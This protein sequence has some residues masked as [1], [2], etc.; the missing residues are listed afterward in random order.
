MERGEPLFF[1][2]KKFLLLLM[3]A[4]LIGGCATGARDLPQD[5]SSI[6]AKNRLRVEDF[7]TAALKLTCS[8]IDEELNI[9]DSEYASKVHD[10]EEKHIQNQ[11][12]VGLFGIFF[13]PVVLA[14]DSNA[15]A[16]EK[17]ENINRAKDQLYKI[18]AFKECPSDLK[19]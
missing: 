19:K 17:I 3:A 16:T 8:Q 9:L 15:E 1:W 18:R 4:S 6:D 2:T 10:I 13:L 14:T 12:G 7:D 11:V 5:Y